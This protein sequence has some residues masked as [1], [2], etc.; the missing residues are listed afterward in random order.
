MSFPFLTNHLYRFGDI[1]ES[2]LRILE[3]RN[4]LIAALCCSVWVAEF[5]WLRAF[6]F[7]DLP[8]CPAGKLQL[9]KASKTR[10]PT[11]ID[12]EP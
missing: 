3:F 2:L 8:A 9:Q 12:I 4:K 11:Q 5:P 6:K 7:D 1:S 10:L